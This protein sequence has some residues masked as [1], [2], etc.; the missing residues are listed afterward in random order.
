MLDNGFMR[1]EC[2]NC[3][4]TF[5]N[6]TQEGGPEIVS[7]GLACYKLNK[8]RTELVLYRDYVDRLNVI[9]KKKAS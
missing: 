9:T 3:G 7:F 1:A 6:L 8:E 4:H 2:D 5:N